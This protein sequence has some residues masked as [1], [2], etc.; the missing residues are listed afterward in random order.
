[1]LAITILVHYVMAPLDVIT[2]IPALS[3]T[4]MYSPAKYLFTSALVVAATGLILGSIA[5]YLTTRKQLDSIRTSSRGFLQCCRGCC[6][7]TWTNTA[8]FICAFISG[9][10]LFGLGVVPLAEQ[11]VTRSYIT[12]LHL[13]FT[14]IFFTSMVSHMVMNTI[15][16]AVRFIKFFY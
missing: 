11:G 9:F 14:F 12:F 2:H 16:A 5:I 15:V 13:F 7:I 3:E 6:R 1:M 10:G 8:S 4:G